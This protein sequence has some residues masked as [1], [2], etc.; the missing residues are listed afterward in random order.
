MKLTDHNAQ[1]SVTAILGIGVTGLSAARF[2]ASRQV[3][4][5]VCDTRD[6]P[7]LLETFKNEFP[8]VECF[9]GADAGQ[10]LQLA[11]ELVVSPGLA[12]DEPLLVQAKQRDIDVIGDIEL[13]ARHVKAPVAAITGSNGKS[14]VTALMGEMAK[15]AGLRVA[16]GGNLGTPALELLADDRELYVLELS[17]FQL[18]ITHSLKPAVSTIL[19]LSEDHLDRYGSMAS[20]LAAKQ[21][22]FHGAEHIVCNRDDSATRP[23]DGDAQISSFGLD[24]SEQ[25]ESDKHQCGVANRDGELWL[26]GADGDL[27][28]VDELRIK[29][30]HNWANALAAMAMGAVLEL[31][32]D[33]MAKAMREFPG[34][35]HRCQTVRTL[36]GV[37]Y[38]NDSKATNVGATLAALEG[39]ADSERRN[40]FWIAGGDGKGAEF[41]ELRS[42]VAATVKL[43]LLIGVDG[44]RIGEAIAD[45]A[46]MERHES[47]Q[48]AVAR[49]RQLAQPGDLVLL[50]PA[51]ASFDMFNN[52]EHRGEM[53]AK[54]AE[55][56]S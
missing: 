53:F 23:V 37:S 30:R 39:L 40:I 16:V 27:M 2:L 29:G 9:L 8:D 10:V 21:R 41:H 15:A 32:E 50:S 46:D 36:D 48:T 54:A 4:F 22:I 31:P 47:L 43:A 51:C 14:T 34:L 44:H 1:N 42:A 6:A 17:S 25:T 24:A 26:H 49:A 20:Y 13:F 56:L 7:P 28:P 3:A 33:A 35:D 45:A 12:P 5:V 38:I 11:A 52:F 18:E 19:N 55:A